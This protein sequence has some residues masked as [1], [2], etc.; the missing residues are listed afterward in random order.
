MHN[1]RSSPG[2]GGDDR[3]SYYRMT[4]QDALTALDAIRDLGALLGAD[5]NRLAASKCPRAPAITA[6]QSS[7]LPPTRANRHTANTNKYPLASVYRGSSAMN[8][9]GVIMK[10]AEDAFAPPPSKK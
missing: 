3:L 8:G 7:N 10:F 4:D 1:K 9:P 5:P 2:E 6:G